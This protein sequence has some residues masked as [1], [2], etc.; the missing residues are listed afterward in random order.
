MKMLHTVVSWLIYIGT[1]VACSAPVLAQ[2]HVSQTCNNNTEGSRKSIQCTFT[3]PQLGMVWKGRADRARKL[4]VNKPKGDTG[5]DVVRLWIGGKA[6]GEFIINPGD[7]VQIFR[8]KGQSTIVARVEVE[9][10]KLP[11][12]GP[13]V[14]YV[15][16]E[17]L[18][19]PVMP[20]LSKCSTTVTT[21]RQSICWTGNF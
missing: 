11:T 13:S 19:R 7:Q 4:Y 1:A 18:D 20:D 10:L 2:S 8:K 9:T 21:D 16:F 3:Q 12:S 6:S 14:I 5:Q 15:H 17:T